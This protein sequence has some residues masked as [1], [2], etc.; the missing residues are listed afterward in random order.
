MLKLSPRLE[1]VPVQRALVGLAQ[2]G[3]VL[4][5]EALVER[6]RDQVYALALRLLNSA[7]DAAEVV[8]QSF[9]L[10][11]RNLAQF[12]SD[13]Q[14]G[15]W[16]QHVTARDSLGRLPQRRA[17]EPRSSLGD[18]ERDDELRQAIEQAT[19]ALA[20][21]NRGALVL[22]DLEGLGWADIAQLTHA[23]VQ[24][25]KRRVHSA[26]LSVRAAIGAFY[27]VGG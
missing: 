19:A 14:F 7:E 1:A 3:D 20:D 17:V 16:V 4:A 21:E 10:A 24:A 12:E 2:Q 6:H 11:Y 26:R 18:P 25:V 5:F 8:Q 22:R 13:A 27:D 9:V 15:S 23:T